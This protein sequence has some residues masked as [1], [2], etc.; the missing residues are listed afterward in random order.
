MLI[1][2]LHKKRSMSFP[3]CTALKYNG[4]IIS[5]VQ[6]ETNIEQFARYLCHR[7]MR[8]GERVAIALPNCPE[9]I[10]AYLGIVRAG[11]VAVPLNMLQAPQEL[12]YILADSESK[13]IITNPAIGAQL[14]KAPNI[15][16]EMIILTDECL[17]DIASAPPCVFAKPDSEDICT[18][19]YTSGTTGRPKAA[20][21]T[22]NNLLSNVKSMDEAAGLG[23]DEN[24]LTVLPMFHSFGWTVCVLYPLSIGCVITILDGLRPKEMLHLLSEEGIT[25]FC[26]VHRR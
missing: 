18:F 8:T 19:L 9:F 1:S 10:Y 26:G 24:F 7:G 23:C 12:L 14:S 4:N 13:Y 15:S 17:K 20:M 3:N 21:L 25:V 16:L 11:G 5:Y 22:H 2:D 6:L